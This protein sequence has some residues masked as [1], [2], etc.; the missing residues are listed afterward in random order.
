M[1][2]RQPQSFA[3]H[4]R[5]VPAYH[6]FAFGVLT[7]NLLFRLFLLFRIPRLDTVGIIETVIGLLVSIALV[8]LAFYARV[9][10]LAAQD[11]VIRLEERMRLGR[12]LPSGLQGRIEELSTG[13]LVAL[14]FASDEE[15]PELVQKVLDGGI[16]DRTAIKKMIRTWRPDYQRA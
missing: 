14:R 7:I 3:N 5:F 12:L 6:F 2:E 11:R 16:R 9:F 8:L 15:L 10:P 1:A 4:A 13:Q